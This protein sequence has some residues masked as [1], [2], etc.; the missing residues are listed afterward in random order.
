VA[1]LGRT[2]IFAGR[3]EEALPPIERAKRYSPITPSGVS[4]W[5]GVAYHTLGRYEEA[6]AAF[7]R[8]RAG[9]PKGVLAL[10]FLA[11]TYAD[12]GRMEEASAM[13][14]KVLEV[15]PGFKV[16]GFV[17][18]LAFKDHTKTEHARATLLQLGLPK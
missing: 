15:S 4:R 11:L 5:E 2:L 17:N 3:P 10:A 7:E 13:A 12:M 1:T 8:A 16:K 6:I 9:N 18:I 14:Q